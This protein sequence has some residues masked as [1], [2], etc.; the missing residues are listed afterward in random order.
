MARSKRDETD[1]TLDEPPQR[2]HEKQP[3]DVDTTIGRLGSLWYV[4]NDDGSPIS[5]GY[6]EIHATENGYVGEIGDR[7]ERVKFPSNG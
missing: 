2:W 1:R 3:L 7:R 4:L 5:Q 6:H